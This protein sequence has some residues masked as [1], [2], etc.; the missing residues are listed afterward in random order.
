MFVRDCLPAHHAGLAVG[1][2]RHRQILAPDAAR[3]ELQIDQA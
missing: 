2:E 1:R 3:A